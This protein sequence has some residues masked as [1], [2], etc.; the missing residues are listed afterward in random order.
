LTNKND[1]DILNIV[2]ETK[3]LKSNCQNKEGDLMK[4]DKKDLHKTILSLLK[5]YN[6]NRNFT[7]KIEDYMTK[8]KIAIGRTQ[9]ILNQNTPIQ[10][11]SDIELCILTIALYKVEEDSKINPEI[12]FHPEEIRQATTYIAD[13]YKVSNMIVIDNVDR[14]ENNVYVCNSIPR[15]DIAN[16]FNY[17]QL[18]F[19]PKVQRPTK[20]IV[21]DNGIIELADIDSNAVLDM[22]QKM[23]DGLFFSNV[24]TVNVRKTGTEKKP[25]YNAN[26]RKLSI[27]VDNI[28]N[29]LDLTDG[30][31]RVGAFVKV[32]EQEPDHQ[33]TTMLRI[34]YAEEK[35]AQR[36]IKQEATHTDIPEETLNF[37]DSTDKYMELTKEIDTEL[38][39][40]SL[41][42]RFAHDS[43]EV[44]HG[45][46]YIT[47]NTFNLAL[48]EFFQFEDGREARL[49]KKFLVDGFNEITGIFKKDFKNRV[50]SKEINVITEENSF[51]GYMKILSELIDYETFKGK[52]DWENDLEVRLKQIDYNKEA[53]HWI[54]IG[55]FS[56]KVNKS[57]V[58]RIGR[59]F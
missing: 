40:N 24:I 38:G 43:I 37:Y 3:V 36:F 11:I 21:V 34:M 9:A 47:Y 19:N 46:K 59:S 41:F 39:I 29:F 18:T 22:T 55:L 56:N 58:K 27:F 49:L 31:H 28:I 10:L 44:A 15:R 16:M 50:K 7:N 48:K 52:T 45:E 6:S 8:K 42:N 12:Y 25:V 17:G 30:M 26:K 4:R 57:V 20:K 54:E 23:K 1:Y 5:Q 53:S 35:E 14:I 2:R 13:T 51:I 33:G 32:L